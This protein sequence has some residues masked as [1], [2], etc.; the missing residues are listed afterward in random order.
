MTERDDQ[1]KGWQAR[2]VVMRNAEERQAVKLSERGW[3]CIPPDHPLIA[4]VR[5]LLAET[6]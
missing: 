4:R 2:A 5:A 6:K 3:E 1:K